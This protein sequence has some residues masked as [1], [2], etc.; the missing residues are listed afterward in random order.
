MKRLLV[1]TVLAAMSLSA[2]ACQLSPLAATVGSSTIT[3]SQL[4]TE[5]LLI[6]G[7]Q[8]AQCALE[9]QGVN[10]PSPLTGVGDDTVT[11]TF[12]TFELST[13]VLE[14]L[15]SQDLARRHKTVTSS[16]L[17]V[18]RADFVSQVTVPA[19]STNPCPSQIDGQQLVDQ[20]PTAFVKE[21]VQFLADQELLAA[22]LGKIDISSAALRKYYDAN[23]SQFQEI[24]LSDIAVATQAQAQSIRAAVVAGTATF[25]AEAQQNSLDTSNSANGGAIPCIPMSQVQNTLILSAVSTLQVGQLSQPTFEPSTGSGGGA[26]LL[27]EMDGR[28]LTPFSDAE[29][30]IRAQ[31][32]SA[33]NGLVSAEFSKLARAAKVD[34][35]PRYGSW[36]PSQGIKPPPTP[37]AVDLLSPAADQLGGTPGLQGAA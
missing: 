29:S 34:V 7:N 31:L 10:L 9:I 3:R 30:Q 36:S 16:D 17:S 32:L 12:S 4:D 5:L 6:A 28:P 14:K 13:L 25:P 22:T 19:S 2:T 27:L 37:P 11:S 35:D 18:A 21:Q 20:L 23:P 26:W 15:I 1:M 8:Y 24:C 33:Q